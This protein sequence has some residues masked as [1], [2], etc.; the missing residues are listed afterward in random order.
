MLGIILAHLGI[1]S[2]RVIVMVLKPRIH[3]WLRDALLSSGFML[4][5]RPSLALG[6][7]GEAVGFALD[8]RERRR[9]ERA[10][11]GVFQ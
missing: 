3:C 5:R 10:G 8:P 1:H 2:V 9:R 4:G 7:R 6:Y 11:F